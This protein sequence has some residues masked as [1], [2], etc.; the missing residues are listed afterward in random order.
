MCVQYLRYTYTHTFYRYGST[1][2]Y[3]R[4]KTTSGL[5]TGVLAVG[6]CT[7]CQ[8]Q[9][10]KRTSSTQDSHGSPYDVIESVSC[11]KLFVPIP[12]LSEYFMTLLLILFYSHLVRCEAKQACVVCKT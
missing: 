7:L 4:E 12:G 11:S 5:S 1:W 6:R 9:T 3:S 2:L 8:S 10:S